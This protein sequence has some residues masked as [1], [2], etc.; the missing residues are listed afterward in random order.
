VIKTDDY[1]KNNLY[2]K[3]LS[4]INSILGQLQKI[5]TINKKIDEL[6]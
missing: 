4:A 1:K 2:V 5:K 3:E 6:N